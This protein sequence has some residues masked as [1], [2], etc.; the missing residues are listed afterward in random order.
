[1]KKCLLIS[2]ILIQLAS[3]TSVK[4]YNA[5]ISKQH[6]VEALQ[7][8]IDKLFKQLQKHHPKLYQ[9]TP[10]QDLKF[11]FDSLKNAIKTPMNSR[12]FYKKLA[13]VVA[14]VRQ[15]HVSV[16]SAG[17]RFKKKERKELIKRKFEFYKLDFE[18][19]NNKLWIKA[20]RGKDSTLVGC[21]VVS[22]D[23]E[24]AQDLTERFKTRFASDGY[25]TT[26]HN[27][28]VSKGFTTFY[29][30]DKGFVDSL[31]IEFRK[32]D[33]LFTK[34]LRRIA[35]KDTRKLKIPKDSLKKI[36][37]KKL[38]K[39]EKQQRRLAKRKRRKD[40]RKY[41]YI[42]SKKQYTRKFSLIGKDSSVAY[43]K[44]RG[45]S[46]GNYKRF[47]KESFA[48]MDSLKTEN[49]I[50]D[51]RDNGGGRIA[52]IDKLYSYLTDKEYRFI[53]ESEVNSRAPFFKMIMSN[54]TPNSLKVLGGVVSPLIYMHNVLHTKKRNGKYYYS[55]GESKVQKPNPL[56][57]KGNMYVLINGNSFSASSLISTHL[58]ATNRATFVGEETGGAY[59]GCVAGI[60]KIYRLPETRLRVRMGLMQI[61][62]PY[63]QEPDGYG[64]K[65]DVEI[66]PTIKDRQEGKDPELDWVLNKL[67]KT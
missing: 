36:K 19:L 67:G 26:L 51:L 61:E 48:L 3:C 56:N 29:Y 11:K 46:N 18:Y 28:Y 4:T 45:F 64:I 22:I 57:Y 60:Y 14:S 7:S 34:T 39:S 65:P 35:K 5:Q 44:I 41:G 24:T 23:G 58:K 25:N 47:Y 31:K 8:D 54:T 42:A 49:F 55:F 53:L 50:L 9:Y 59:N 33:S 15:G 37:P 38:T 17:K 13:P 6:S 62:A 43:M 2:F 32:N 1:M 52:E 27:R 21:E 10:E 20:N 66:L 40:N 63:R 16:G 12:A 30:K